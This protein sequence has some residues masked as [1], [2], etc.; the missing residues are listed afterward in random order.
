MLWDPETTA[1]ISAANHHQRCDR[2]PF[3]G[4]SVRGQPA[5]VI[6]GGRVVCRDGKLD[7]ERGAGR[8]LERS[9]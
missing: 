7:V 2:T 5:V 9:L 6:A 3:E 1:T 8:F 4:F